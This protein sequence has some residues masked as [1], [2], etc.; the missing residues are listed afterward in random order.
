[1][2]AIRLT[3]A[4]LLSGLTAFAWAHT[5]LNAAPPEEICTE[6]LA[7]GL[8]N[9]NTTFQVEDPN[10]DGS[11]VQFT[12]VITLVKTTYQVPQ[13]MNGLV[14][15][16]DYEITGLPN[17]NRLPMRWIFRHPE[18]FGRTGTQFDF[19]ARPLKYTV[20]DSMLYSFSKPEE[21]AQ[22]G[23]WQAELWYQN[24]MLAARRF[25]VGT[26]DAQRDG[27]RVEI[28]NRQPPPCYPVEQF[29]PPQAPPLPTVESVSW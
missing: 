21:I 28:F 26:Y 7:Y 23:Q 10:Q 9:G 16:F 1:M 20:R 27:E 25:Q 15:G 12:E 8:Y 13:A 24:K 19:I 3:L 17:V 4:A 18:M 11:Y 5:P 6:I 29:H 14:F 22:A 2:F